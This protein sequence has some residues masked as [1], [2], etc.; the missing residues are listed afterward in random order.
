M[1]KGRLYNIDLVKGI[2]IILVIV[3]HMI[4]GRVNG[5]LVRY[6]IYSVHMPIFI[7]ISGYLVNKSFLSSSTLIDVLRKYVPRVMIPWGLGVI[8]YFF[9]VKP[10]R[11]LSIFEWNTIL[12]LVKAFIK[13]YYHLWYIL[14]Y[15]SYIVIT[16]MFL[17]I[18][19]NNQILLG[20]SLAIGIVSK[21]RLYDI[22][23]ASIERIV[24]IIHYDFRIYNLFFFILGIC[25]REY[26]PKIE[27]SKVIY[28]VMWLWAI[29]GWVYNIL[30]FYNMDS[31]LKQLLYY[32]LNIPM[33]II[34]ILLCK[35]GML[36]RYKIIEYIGQQSLSFYLWHVVPILVASKIVGTK[37]N[38]MYYVLCVALLVGI[39]FVVYIRS[40]KAND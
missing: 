18:R 13:P 9:A 12:E 14:G 26:I 39:Y 5:N 15:I 35:K 21:L 32:G 27:K 23:H 10:T 20:V 29:T 3:G 36:P 19:L 11:I 33:C 25:L 24:S 7:A 22:D 4:P 8:V 40:K 31:Q 34:I 6:I 17:K 16:W 30:L 38:M 37:N 28:L 2:L 1:G